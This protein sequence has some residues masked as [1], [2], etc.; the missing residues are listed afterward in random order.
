MSLTS[1]GQPTLA[2]VDCGSGSSRFSLYSIHEDDAL[3]H[4]DRYVPSGVI[5]TL[6][7]TLIAGTEAMQQWCT[8]LKG[9]VEEHGNNSDVPVIVGA[10]GGVR[11]ALDEGDVCEEDLD[12]FQRLLDATFG[13]GRR[14]TF[15]LLAGEEEAACELAAVR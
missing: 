10:T 9:I 8:Q 11:N 5:P 2:I 4:E 1:M 14:A 15:R 13:G 3:L 6:V 12:A 7:P